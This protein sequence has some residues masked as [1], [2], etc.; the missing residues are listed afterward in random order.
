MHSLAAAVAVGEEGEEGGEGEEGEEGEE[1]GGGARI[2]CDL[3][4]TWRYT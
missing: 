2:G 3:L 4:C 1:G